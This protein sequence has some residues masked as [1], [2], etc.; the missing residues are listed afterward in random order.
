MIETFN[1]LFEYNPETGDLIRKR[2]G[3]KVGSVST[4]GALQVQIQGKNYLVHRIAWA[5]SHGK[6]PDGVIDHINRNN[7]DNRLKNL[8]DVSVSTNTRNSGLCSHN[9]SG[10][11]GVSWV[12]GR[13][14]WKVQMMAG[15]PNKCLGYRDNLLDAAALRKSAELEHGFG[16]VSDER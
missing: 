4:S 13:N 5:M 3:V 9:T 1:S 2:N 12:N 11:K 6:M 8:R 14:R 16:P 15:G 7:R 10:I